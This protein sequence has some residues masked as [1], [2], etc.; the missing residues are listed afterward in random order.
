MEGCPLTA[1]LGDGTRVESALAMTVTE[2]A[3]EGLAAAGAASA[4]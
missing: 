2:A 1:V 4:R 3:G